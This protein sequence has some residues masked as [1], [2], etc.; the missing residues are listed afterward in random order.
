MGSLLFFGK[1]KSNFSVG[2]QDFSPVIK[3]KTKIIDR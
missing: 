2:W 1:K 3:S